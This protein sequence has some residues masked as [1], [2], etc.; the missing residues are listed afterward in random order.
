[1]RVVVE[2]AE[3]VE[4]VFD[5]AVSRDVSIASIASTLSRLAPKVMLLAGQ[6]DDNEIPC[7]KW[8]A[9][10]QLPWG[11][12]RFMKIGDVSRESRFT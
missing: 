10:V 11:D 5:V 7:V 9:P 2:R 12:R 6:N 8:Q 1:M 3:A 4:E